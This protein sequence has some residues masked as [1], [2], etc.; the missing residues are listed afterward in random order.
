MGFLEN[1]KTKATVRRHLCEDRRALRIT[2]V[3][4][5][6]E[7]VGPS[8]NQEPLPS[9]TCFYWLKPFLQR[10]VLELTHEQMRCRLG[11]GAYL[12]E[13]AGAGPRGAGPRGREGV[14]LEE[15]WSDSTSRLRKQKFHQPEALSCSLRR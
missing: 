15:A 11:G 14:K 1:P 7:T 6:E 12:V 4:E 3:F 13:V 8:A 9:L 10:S 5:G 2:H